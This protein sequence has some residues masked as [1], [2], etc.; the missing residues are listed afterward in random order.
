M[1]RIYRDKK[2]ENQNNQLK[3]DAEIYARTPKKN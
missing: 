3:M 1:T 2:K